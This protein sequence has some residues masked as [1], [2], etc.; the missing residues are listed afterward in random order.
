MN[1]QPW[2]LVVLTGKPLSKIRE[3][4]VEKLNAGAPPSRNIMSWDGRITAFIESDR[5]TSL[6]ISFRSWI[7]RGKTRRSEL[8][9]WRVVFAFLMPPLL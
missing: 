4:N 2:E 5:W 7:F 8:H 3:G 6:S 9:G 1:T